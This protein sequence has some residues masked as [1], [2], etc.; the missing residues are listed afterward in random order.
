MSKYSH[1]EMSEKIFGQKY[2]WN[3]RKHDYEPYSRT[4]M[5]NKLI[6]QQDKIADLEAKLAE[7]EKRIQ[8]YEEIVEQK[9]KEISFANRDKTCIV[10]QLNNPKAYV[11]LEDYKQLIQQLAEKTLTIEQI[12]KAFIENRSLWKGK[13]EQANQDKISFCIEKLE[14]VKEEMTYNGN[15]YCEVRQCSSPHTPNLNY[16]WFNYVVFNK[17]IDNQ[18]KQLEED[19]FYVITYK[20]GAKPPMWLTH[21]HEDKGE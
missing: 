18:I 3:E 19:G 7:S 12:N 20:Q 8:A 9:D 10:K 1:Y 17:F 14:K 11:L 13:Y 4:D 21:Q 2:K 5:W 16:A 15:G 6:E